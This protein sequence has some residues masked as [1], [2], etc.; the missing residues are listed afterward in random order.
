[1]PITGDM[2]I[3]AASHHGRDGDIRAIDPATGE[4]L[5][6]V[7]GGGGPAEVE[8]ACALAE[9]AFDAFRETGLEQR[10]AFLETVAQNILDIG[11]ELITRAM[12][13]SGLPRPRL[14]GERARTV[15]Q[16]RLFAQVVREGSWL[17]ARIDPALP[18]RAPLPRSDLRQRHIPL[19]PVA[20]FGASNFPLAFSVAGG[21]TASAFAAGC[22]VVVKSHSAHPGTSELV[23]RAIQAA[24]ASCGLP[25]G[26]FSLL[27]G[28][29]NPIGTALVADPRIK[30][31][32]F[33][34]SR[35]GG[36][37]LMEV[38]AKRPEPIPVY[39]EMSSINP[40]FLMPAALAARAEALGKAFVASLTMGAGQFCT[41]PGILLG[42]DGPD[43]DRFVATAVEALGGSAALTM[44]TPGIH[45]AYDSGVA[46]L[47]GSTAVATLARGLACSGP[48]QAQ[49]ALFATTAEQ[50][51]A[52]AALQEEV[53][54]AASLL[55]RC[56]D[57]ATMRKVA[58][59]LEGQLTATL[60][61]DAADAAAVAGLVPVLERKAG[62]LLANGWPTGVEVCHA[63]VHG[64]PFPA[65]SDSRTTS[66]GTLA[67]R[68]FLRP[69]C[70][71]DLPAEL[72]PEAL[73]DGNPL[74]IWRRVDGALGRE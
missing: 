38:A 17:D 42:V 11:D 34:G 60:Q 27:F 56:P 52:D 24:V 44:L 15:G 58:E 50:F 2:L 30:A 36:L 3:G 33:T 62:R 67:I 29:G 70:Y 47:A 61:M 43:L 31:V 8:R 57:V 39:A 65:T 9:A 22:P 69:V 63:M 59:R 26:V 48:N 45:A 37:A 28:T 73:R 4:A 1:M 71:Q 74:G 23:G 41:N 25:E 5:D 64:G 49:A 7:F 13:E 10:A 51:L 35:R 14:E 12:A 55:I 21:D 54:G 66:V 32:G 16:L 18:Q 68:R 40:V 19:G 20:V 53:F 6:P 72:L 46:A